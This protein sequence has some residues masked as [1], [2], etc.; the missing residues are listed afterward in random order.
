MTHVR[1]MSFPGT[2]LFVLLLISGASK[3]QT[4]LQTPASPSSPAAPASLPKFDVISVK[5]DK[6]GGNGIRSGLTP[7]GVR[8]TNAPLHLL[9]TQAYGVS[10]DQLIGEPTWSRTTRFDIEAKV[11]AADVPVL[12]TFNFDQRRMQA[13]QILTERFGLVLHHETRELPELVLTVAR[14]GSKLSEAKIDPEHPMSPGSR[15]NFRLSNGPMGQ[16]LQAQGAR[17][18]GLLPLLSNETGRTVVDKTGLTGNYDFMLTWTQDPP[19]GPPGERS[20][21][22][23]TGGIPQ[24][25]SIDIRPTLFTALQ[26]HLG[27]KLESA[28]G[29]VDVLVID[30][31]E[32]PTEN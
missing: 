31:V 10:D 6:T 20:A 13:Q 12:K 14:G 26:E 2:V 7:D 19:E 1:T 16:R 32:M 17:I 23:D 24:S 22:A 8:V 9:L 30:H 27:L 11:A 3:A 21:T 18:D 28:K 4:P 29:P 5:L 25:T 15:G